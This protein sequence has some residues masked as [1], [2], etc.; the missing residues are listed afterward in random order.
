MVG[1][2]ARVGCGRDAVLKQPMRKLASRTA[3]GSLGLSLLVALAA[4]RHVLSGCR[5]GMPFASS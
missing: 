1:A 3:I 5:T 4:F 2:A